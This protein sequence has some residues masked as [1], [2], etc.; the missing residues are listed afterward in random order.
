MSET[1]AWSCVE[2][3][4]ITD[5]KHIAD[6][7]VYH[8]YSVRPLTRDQYSGHCMC[9]ACKHGVVHDSDCSVHNMP[10]S[11]NGDCSCGIV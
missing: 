2:D 7:W 10:E 9:P 6:N 3:G 11:Q 1:V 8:G 5:S 4:E